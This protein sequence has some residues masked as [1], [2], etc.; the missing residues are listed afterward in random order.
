MSNKRVRTKTTRDPSAHSAQTLGEEVAAV[1]ANLNTLVED[2]VGRD[3]L[4]GASDMHRREDS[5]PGHR[6][7]DLDLAVK[8]GLPHDVVQAAEGGRVTR[9]SRSTM[10]KRL[11]MSRPD[12]G[13]V[14][15][16]AANKRL[17]VSRDAIDAS[18]AARLEVSRE[19]IDASAAVRLESSRATDST[20]ETS[21]A[22]MSLVMHSA[23]GSAG[24]DIGD[25]GAVLSAFGE[26]AL[27]NLPAVDR[28]AL[29]ASNAPHVLRYELEEYMQLFQSQKD[30]DSEDSEDSDIDAILTPVHTWSNKPWTVVT[31]KHGV[32]N[33]GGEKQHVTA[34]P[35]FFPEWFDLSD[36]EESTVTYSTLELPKAT[37]EVQIQAAIMESLK[38]PKVLRLGAERGA[39]P[40]TL[41]LNA[42]IVEV[43][44]D[45]ETPEAQSKGK[46]VDEAEKGPDYEKL[47]HGGRPKAPALQARSI[48]NSGRRMVPRHDS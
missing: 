12:S 11:E 24:D 42:V 45:T 48:R 1:G 14:D 34:R 6:A 13:A 22:I 2:T 36:E 17:E 35:K 19:A 16:S 47:H 21:A 18:A 15:N 9:G 31:N 44:D 4:R 8:W 37:E 28:N 25:N 40:S 41:K 33:E 39:G 26:L 30:T 7:S 32:R 10:P 43:T 46:G 20:V 27:G 23:K 29:R 38:V 3:L 5:P